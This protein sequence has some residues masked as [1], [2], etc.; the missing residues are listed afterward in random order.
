MKA[1]ERAPLAACKAKIAAWTAWHQAHF[2]AAFFTQW[3]AAAAEG[4]TQPAPQSVHDLLKQLRK[5][6]EAAGGG[7]GLR[8]KAAAPGSK[9]CRRR[10]PAG[11]VSG[12]TVGDVEWH[13]PNALPKVPAASG[14]ATSLAGFI[15]SED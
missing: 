15:Q 6:A 2:P 7:A 10:C 1:Q 11:G 4:S 3:A 13:K 9:Q 14:G 12:K 5:R 8:R